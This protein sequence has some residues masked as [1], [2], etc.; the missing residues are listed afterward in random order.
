MAGHSTPVYATKGMESEMAYRVILTY[1]KKS[2]KYYSTG[3]YQSEKKELFEIWQEVRDMAGCHPG[4][5]NLWNKE[6]PISVDVPDHPNNHPHLVILTPEIGNLKVMQER[7]D[8]NVEMHPWHPMNNPVEVKTLGKL[9]EEVNE[10]G[11]ACARCLIQ[12]VDE[13]EPV[14]LMVNREWL[15]DEIAD[16]LANI[17][18]VT[19]CFNLD[20]DHIEERVHT[21]Q[22][23]LT[24]W[25]EMA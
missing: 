11:Q 17:A 25:H 7:A 12:G 8:C 24:K 18:L 4:L 3:E 13:A 21:K 5:V 1:F 15:E 2:G 16:V 20:T 22:E 10:L 6:G 19:S 23:R 9:L 14:T